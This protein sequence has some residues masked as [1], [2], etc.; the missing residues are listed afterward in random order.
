MGRRWLAA[1]SAL[2]MGACAPQVVVPAAKTSLAAIAGIAP[3]YGPKTVSAVPN[4]AAI[5]RRIWLPELDAGYDPQGLAVDDAGIYV[6]AYRSDSLDVQAVAAIGGDVNAGIINREPLR[7]VAGIEFRQPDAPH[8]R[9]RIGHRADRF[10]A[11]ARCNAGNRRERGLRRGNDYLRGTRPH[12]QRR[13]GSQPAPPHR[14]LQWIGRS[15]RG[16]RSG[17]AKVRRIHHLAGEDIIRRPL[18]P[19]PPRRWAGRPSY[20]DLD[21][22]PLTSVSTS[23]WRASIATRWAASTW[24]DQ[25]R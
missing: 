9:R 2:V 11:V 17:P 22:T 8:D 25:C 13:G 19:W 3:S 16:R 23:A 5:V 21:Q 15:R 12:H 24:T 6:S 20:A 7:V 1:A 14:S 18:S 10:R 4:A